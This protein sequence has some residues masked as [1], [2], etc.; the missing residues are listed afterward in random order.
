MG[1]KQLDE[2][3]SSALG[4][5]SGE[6][7]L[8]ANLANLSSVLFHGLPGVNWVGFYLWDEQDNELILGP[9]Q[10]QPACLRIKSGRGV[11]GQAFE[12]AKS[13]RVDDVDSFPDH[14]T[15]DPTSKSELVIP[16]QKGKNVYGVLDMDAPVKSFFTS[17]T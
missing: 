7:N 14:I 10:G 12:N 13:L 8:V 11:C 15:C 4:I 3:K 9:F 6:P 17:R 5:I 16:L 2:I 1:R